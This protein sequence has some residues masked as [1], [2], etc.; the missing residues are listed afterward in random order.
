MPRTQ[1]TFEARVLTYFQ[2]ADLVSAELLL[3]LI[4]A[5][6]R[7]R[8]GPK[9]TPAKKPRGGKTKSTEKDVPLPI[10]APRMALA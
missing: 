5:T 8:R 3:G 6:I 1:D 10:D 9:A 4:Q 2:T 7:A